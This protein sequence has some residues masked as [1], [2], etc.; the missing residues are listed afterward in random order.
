MT[1]NTVEAVLKTVITV[2]LTTTA[3]PAT[4]HFTLATKSGL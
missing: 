2:Q 4:V 1:R 3:E